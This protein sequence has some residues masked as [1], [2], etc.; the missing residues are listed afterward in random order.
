[1][2]LP[3]IPNALD[4]EKMRRRHGLESVLTHS[5]LL[6]AASG[7]LAE[8]GHDEIPEGLRQEIRHEEPETL[9][10]VSNLSRAAIREELVEYL[11]Q[12]RHPSCQ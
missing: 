4:L 1:M 12:C 9:S 10:V 7:N 11:F 5:L 2:H 6:L 8:H 3:S